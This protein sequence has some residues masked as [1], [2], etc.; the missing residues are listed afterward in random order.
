MIGD[1]SHHL[2]GFEDETKNYKQFHNIQRNKTLFM[3][4]TEK[5]IGA[6]YNQIVY[7]MDD[8]TLFGKYIVG[9]PSL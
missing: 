2:V 7:T 6:K 4:A 9:M 5:N 8:E 1:E 3:T